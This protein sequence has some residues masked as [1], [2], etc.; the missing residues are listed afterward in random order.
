MTDKNARMEIRMTTTAV[1]NVRAL[2]RQ[3]QKPIALI[4]RTAIGTHVRSLRRQAKLTPENRSKLGDATKWTTEDWTAI[5]MDSDAVQAD[6]LW[7]EA[8]DRMRM[9]L[10]LTT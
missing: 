6:D 3:Q 4:V 5:R 10:E 8:F 2:A 7:P 9:H 1:Q